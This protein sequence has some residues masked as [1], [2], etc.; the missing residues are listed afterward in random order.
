MTDEQLKKQLQALETG[1]KTAFSAIYTELKTPVYTVLVR[2]GRPSAGGL[3]QAVP[4]ASPG[5][6]AQSLRIPDGAQSGHRRPAAKT[7]GGID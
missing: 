4:S 2:L 6:K 3:S 5:G 1:D 7:A